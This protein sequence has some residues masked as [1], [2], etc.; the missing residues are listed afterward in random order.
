[1]IIKAKNGET[2]L[3]LPA[4]KEMIELDWMIFNNITT[5]TYPIK[6]LNREVII[7]GGAVAYYEDVCAKF[8]PKR[9]DGKVAAKEC[10]TSAKL[11]DFVFNNEVGNYTLDEY[12]NDAEI[13]A[14]I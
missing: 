13:V 1:M 2:L 6:D 8:T 7:E 3:T 9:S 12:Q 11:I 14:K 4:F 10:A 5:L